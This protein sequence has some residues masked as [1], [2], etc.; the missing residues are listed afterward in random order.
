VP[1]RECI[2]FPDVDSPPPMLERYQC[3]AC[4]APA[5]TSGGPPVEWK[6]PPTGRRFALEP[7]P[8][9]CTS[10]QEKWFREN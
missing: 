5:W 1:E 8:L 2:P 9:L 3:C 4:G 10:C 6:R 7:D